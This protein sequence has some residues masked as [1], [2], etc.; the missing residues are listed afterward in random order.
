MALAIVT[1]VSTL[2]L[3]IAAFST[4]TNLEHRTSAMGYAPPLLA[5]VSSHESDVTSTPHTPELRAASAFCD[6]SS[7]NCTPSD[8][9]ME[10]I[11]TD[12][13]K[14]CKCCNSV[15]LIRFLGLLSRFRNL[16]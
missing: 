3:V 12:K 6:T 13:V 1:V 14:S 7:A 8:P 10:F 2:P 15:R 5:C 16:I 9:A 11:T 4:L